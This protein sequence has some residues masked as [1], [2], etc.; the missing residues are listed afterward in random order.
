MTG[1]TIRQAAGTRRAGRL[2]WRDLHGRTAGNLSE[3]TRGTP[4]GT[5]TKGAWN[6]SGKRLPET[7]FKRVGGLP[8]RPLGP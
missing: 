1:E 8:L 2:T 4:R 7:V 5:F 3:R 6:T